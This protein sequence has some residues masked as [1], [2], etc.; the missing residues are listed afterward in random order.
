M[1]DMDSEE[2]R[3]D[4]K[5]DIRQNRLVVDFLA[6]IRPLEAQTLRP[7]QTITLIRM[8]ILLD[9]KTG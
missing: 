2:V 8:I 9:E 3:P 4:N 1:I 5:L 7:I 6:G